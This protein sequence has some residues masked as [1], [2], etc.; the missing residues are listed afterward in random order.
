M[1]RL[2][3]SGSLAALLVLGLLLMTVLGACQPI[4]AEKA[5]L[6]WLDELETGEDVSAASLDELSETQAI[7]VNRAID[8]LAETADVSPD[9]ITF[10]SIEEVEWPDASLG[11]PEPDMMYAAML[12]PGYVITLSVGEGADAETVEYHTAN[13]ADSQL[14]Q[15]DD[16]Q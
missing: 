5:T 3:G 11:C 1:L 7:L 8:D 15:C 10:V 12:T 2:N 13:S 9:S 14:V 16:T 4:T 6:P